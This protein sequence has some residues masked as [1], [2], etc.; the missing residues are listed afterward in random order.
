[1]GKNNEWKWFLRKNIAEILEIEKEDTDFSNNFR[2]DTDWYLLKG[3]KM[4][5]FEDECGKVITVDEFLK[6]TTI[7]DLY[8][9]IQ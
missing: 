8:K 6:A 2:N 5:V 3:F 7:G 1:M 4:L 9:L